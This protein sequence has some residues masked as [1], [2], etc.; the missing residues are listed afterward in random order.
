MGHKRVKVEGDEAALGYI[1]VSCHILGG[2]WKEIMF[3][4]VNRVGNLEVDVCFCS[5]V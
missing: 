1:I 2:F 5:G 4:G 3:K